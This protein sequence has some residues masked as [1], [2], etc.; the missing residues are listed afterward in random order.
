MR[1]SQTAKLGTNRKPN[2]QRVGLTFNSVIRQPALLLPFLF[3]LVTL[4]QLN[5]VASMVVS[6]NQLLRPL[7]ALWV[8]LLILILPAYLLTRNW[9][10][11]SLLLTIFVLGFFSS[12]DFF[13]LVFGFFVLM[14]ICWF[15]FVWLRKIPIRLE[16]FIYILAAIGVLFLA[17]AS[18]LI[19]TML[20]QIPEAQYRQQ[21]ADSANFSL[22]NLSVPAAKPDIYYIVLD[23]YARAD[24]LTEMFDFDNSDFISRLQ[25][26]G[27]I[28]PTANH[29]NYPATPLSIASTLNM[30]YVQALVPALR[31]NRERW[32]MAPLIDHSRVRAVLEPK[33]YQTI[34]LSTNW[35]ITEN[36]TTDIY[37][38]PS[39]VMLSDF[40]G[41]VLD[42]TPLQ[43]FEP[44]LGTFSSLPTAESHRD[45]IRYNFKTL[46]EL[47]NI[48]G[49][50]FVFAHIISPH[51]P[52][53][54]DQDG[55]P[56]DTSDAFTFQDA[57]EFPGA[58]NEYP[59]RYADQ[60]KF[61]NKNV[62]AIVETIMAQSKVPPIIILQA[63]HG[64]GML[65]D[66]TSP[67]NTCIRE[68]FS[69]FAA[70]YLP[71]KEADAIP[72]DISSVNIF[73]IVLNTYFNAH[74]PLLEDK[75]Y[76]YKD[77]QDYYDFEDVTGRLN[78]RC[79]LPRK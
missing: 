3:T 63:D 30:D 70:Y 51:P 66:L 49:P 6:P 77:M 79:V 23:G 67:D 42:M 59:Q 54:F 31:Q 29:S 20:R 41:Y 39:P 57:N 71:G 2:S 50:K 72:S 48:P 75:Q 46:S 27:F 24:I 22:E 5:Y 32:L 56:V 7:F 53:V 16:H 40:E 47:P 11:T 37:L 38:H 55:N 21:V 10:W 73:R 52:F 18:F 60:V 43:I 8:F 65:T 1:T 36:T 17:Y 33:G 62:Q 15:A 76:F 28:I 14:S 19:V 4:L 25:E 34:S 12:A 26:D 45:I 69:P 9:K 64:S 74:L 61:V 68:R 44:V 35:T 58:Q 78:D 13:S